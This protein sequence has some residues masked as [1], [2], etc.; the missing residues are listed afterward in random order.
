MTR[1]YQYMGMSQEAL[2]KAHDEI[3]SHRHWYKDWRDRII[4]ILREMLQKQSRGRA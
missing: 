2:I 4:F 3:M 1:Y